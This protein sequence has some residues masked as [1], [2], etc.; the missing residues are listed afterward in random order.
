M[1]MWR[2]REKG[3]DTTWPRSFAW[4]RRSLCCKRSESC[5]LQ[6]APQNFSE[7]RREV[8]M[9]FEAAIRV[10]CG[11]QCHP[12]SH[13]GP[14]RNAGGCLRMWGGSSLSG[15]YRTFPFPPLFSF[16]SV[17]CLNLKIYKCLELK[18]LNAKQRWV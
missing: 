8:I 15:N 1:I 14:N 7:K 9:D 3:A 6:Q 17:L 18:P 13:I 16:L 2:L 12:R 4:G 11:A 5:F 10:F